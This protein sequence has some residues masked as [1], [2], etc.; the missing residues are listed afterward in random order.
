MQHSLVLSAPTTGVGAT[1]CIWPHEAIEIR[2]GATASVRTPASGAPSVS[3]DRD[4][5]TWAATGQQMLISSRDPAK[6]PPRP[7]PPCPAVSKTSE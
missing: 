6:D 2:A 1:A 7:P 4:G 3:I 5:S